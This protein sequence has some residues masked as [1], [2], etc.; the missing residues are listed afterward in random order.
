[1]GIKIDKK[2]PV[3]KANSRTGRPV[4]YPFDKLK[5]GDSFFIKG[6]PKLKH[7]IYSCLNAYNANRADIKIEITIR[8]EDNGVRVW[9]IK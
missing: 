1:M 8:S 5:V 3:P 7:S 4:K 2:V 9:R 6:N